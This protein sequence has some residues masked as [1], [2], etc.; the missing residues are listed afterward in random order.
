[1]ESVRNLVL[2]GALRLE[3]HRLTRIIDG[4][5]A[6]VI[7]SFKPDEPGN[8]GRVP[9]KRIADRSGSGRASSVFA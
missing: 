8:S 7:S 5:E 1:M 3:K 4:I 9:K 2:L 6:A